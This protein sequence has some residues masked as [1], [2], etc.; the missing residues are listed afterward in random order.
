MK[1]LMLSVFVVLTFMAYV[2]YERFGNSPSQPDQP[3]SQTTAP[4]PQATNSSMMG[5]GMMGSYKDGEYIGSMADAYYGNVQ[6]KITISS[7]KIADVQFLQYPSDRRTSVEIN[8]QAM[9]YLRQEAIQSQNA[10]VDTISGATQTSRAF[11][12]SLQSALNQ[13]S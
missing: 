8:T 9:P 2:A 12:E 3:V 1:K 10:Q 5:R 11:R 6:V 7:G 4:V 13:A